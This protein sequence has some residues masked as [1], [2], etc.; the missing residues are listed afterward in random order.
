M[1][2]I[3]IYVTHSSEFEAKKIWDFLLEKK[4][5]ACYNLFPI[6]SSYWWNWNIENSNEFVTLLKTKTS[7]WEIVKEEIK[8]IHPYK[9]PCIMKTKVEANKEYENWIENECE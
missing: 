3:T 2:F 6:S 7:N 5:I 8:N 4:L 9:I 1:P